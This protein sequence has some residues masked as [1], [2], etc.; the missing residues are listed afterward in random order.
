MIT[1]SSTTL[2]NL[3]DGSPLYSKTYTGLIGSAND[4]ANA[5]FYFAKIHPDS[6]T[7]NYKVKMKVQVTA[8]ESYAETIDIQFG[9]YGS[10]FSSFDAYTTR[11][12][13]VG[14]YYINLYRA[15]QVG[16]ST[17]HKGHALG[18]GL[19][20]SNNPTNTSYKRTVIIDILELDGCTIEMLDTAVKYAS[21]DGTG[22]TNYYGLTEMAVGT[23]GQNA[24]NNTNTHYTQYS[25]NVK[26]GTN[27]IKGYTLI[28]KDSENTWSCFY[29]GAYKVANTGKPVYTGGF[30]LGKIL[31]SAGAGAQTSDSSLD[32]YYNYKSG[33][34]TSTIYDAYPVDLR[35]STNCASTLT[36]QRPV[37]IVGTIENDGL[38][39]LDVSQWWTQTEPTYVDGKVYIYVGIAYSTYQV[40]LSTE[41]PAYVY[42]DGE[43][44]LYDKAQTLQ[45]INT[46][47]NSLETQI[48]SKV[49]TWC[50]KTNPASSWTAEERPN[51]TGD[52]WYYIGESTST[53]KNN[54]TYQYNG[55]TNVWSAYSANPDLFDKIDGKTAIYYGTTNSVISAEEGDYLVDSENDCTYRW[56][57]GAW[58]LAT[59]YKQVAIDAIEIGGRNLV[60]NTADWKNCPYAGDTSTVNGEEFIAPTT[61][62]TNWR[63]IN[64][65]FT[66]T[67]EDIYSSSIV[68]S[69]DVKKSDETP[70]SELVFQLFTT[71]KAYKTQTSGNL[72][73]GTRYYTNLSVNIWRNTENVNKDTWTRVYSIPIIMDEYFNT[74]SYTEYDY[75]A[76]YIGVKAATGSASF[77]HMKIELGNKATDWTPAPEDIE[78]SM[79]EK[80]DNIEIGGRNIL[81]NSA[82]NFPQKYGSSTLTTQSNVAIPE[83]NCTDGL[84]CYGKTG[85]GNSLCLLIN[86]ASHGLS[87][88]SATSVRDQ[89][90]VLSMYIKNNH[91]TNPFF[92]NSNIPSVSGTQ[93]IQ[94]GEAKRV[95]FYA[96]GNNYHVIQIVLKTNAAED[97]YDITFWHPQIEFGNKVTDWTPAPEDIEESIKAYAQSIQSQ[98]DGMAEIHYGTA[99]PTLN[100]APASAWTDTATKDMHVDDLY[101]NTSTGYCYRFT[102]SGSTYS[103]SRIKDSDIT[104]A[105]TAAGNAQ[106]TANNANTLA[107]QKRRI[108][109]SQPTPPYEVGDLWVE[110]SNGDIKKCKTARASG[111]YTANDWELASKYTDD[112]LASEAN[113]KI[114]NLEVGGRNLFGIGSDCATSLTGLITQNFSIVTEDGY[115]CAHA[116]GALGTTAHLTSKIPFTPKPLEK[117]VFSADIKIKDIVLGTTNPMCEFYFSGQ[118]INGSWRSQKVSNTY[119]DGE[120]VATGNSKF[121]LILPSNE[122][123]RVTVKWQFTDAE[124]TANMPPA[125]YLRDCTGEIF[126]KN[127]KYERGTQE[128]D[129]TP[130]PE[131]TQADIDTA[132]AQSV[133]YII[134]T[135]TAATN[136]WTGVTKDTSLQI[137]KTIVYYLP[138][139]G[140]TSAATLNLTLAGGGT[141]GAKNVR[142]NNTN[143]TNHYP[144]YS[145]ITLTYDGTYWRTSAY[146]SD[147]TNKTRL[148]NIIIAAEN[149]TAGHIICGTSSGYQNIA[150]YIDFDL[151]MPILYAGSSIAKGATS[152]TRDNNYLANSGVNASTNGTIE[153]GTI[154]KI[155]YL[156]GTITG[157][158]FHIAATPFMTTNTPNQEDDFYY[159]PLGIMYTTTNIYF[160][161]SNR[162]YAYIDGAFQPVDTAAVLRAQD[163]KDRATAV[164]GTCSTGATTVDK[165]VTC[166][167]FTLFDGARIQI[168]FTNANTAVASETTTNSPTLNINGT[169]A[170]PIKIGIETANATN[171][172]YWAAGAKIEFVYDGSAWILQNAPYTLYGSCN[173]EENV[174]EK[175]V[176]CD[177]AVVCKG[178]TIYVDMLYSNTAD[179]NSENGNVTLNVA[180]TIAKTIYANNSTLTT[181]SRYNWNAGEKPSFTFDGQYWQMDKDT[182]PAYI[183]DK[184][185]DGIFVHPVD[186]TTSGWSIGKVFELLNN[187]YSYIKMW[188]EDVTDNL[189]AKIRIG[190]EDQHHILLD[191]EIIQFKKGD[192][193]EELASFSSSGISFDD[194][195]PFKIGNDS[196]YVQFVDNNSDGVADALEIVADRI[197]FRN[198]GD[199]TTQD[200]QEK[201]DNL[202]TDVSNI[203]NSI[204]INPT[205]NTPYVAITTQDAQNT[206]INAG[207][208]LEPTQLSFQLNGQTTATMANDEMNIPTASVTNLFMQSANQSYEKIW[209]M[210]SNGHLSLKVGKQN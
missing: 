102:K 173:T 64:G 9:G 148:Q 187:G 129:W 174:R 167:N 137:G 23:A 112:T 185:E 58:V 202:Q 189:S 51:H 162:L 72:P 147:S 62:G 204:E 142:W 52:L 143:V 13:S 44:I 196:A 141:T 176:V 183:T 33:V 163:A 82:T 161:S 128:T 22:S 29:S 136:L 178:T 98:V 5:S 76:F 158:T 25:N 117:M 92:V 197:S 35:Y 155:L 111:S 172:L 107:G 34:N 97:D 87:V 206:N 205:A 21:I 40:W 67:K 184:D 55:E 53:Y 145:I 123:H 200:I 75:L 99:V 57:N 169:G 94:P 17:N 100:N 66:K 28:M 101:Y 24:T 146:N 12:G 56:N 150:P 121:H 79:Q 4:A 119:V 65:W 130:A 106:T 10:S 195:V 109:V 36:S 203:T 134:G 77:R 120:L 48:D 180:N 32:T 84:R 11:T 192:T 208:K 194:S 144:Q 131:D 140:T 122:W 156:K 80:V 83:F 188:L 90:Y 20:S 191:K 105:A 31:Y 159:I 37:Y 193:S 170:K 63:R 182:V 125:I 74:T 15:T 157:N 201:F 110:G 30:I 138:Y 127:I 47:K 39:H 114:D 153:L 88:S 2:A 91:E 186:D 43:F 3:K 93:S 71:N 166:S 124:F 199:N 115:K 198:G 95:V 104:A 133:E 42:Y 168:T 160:Q 19:R 26:A 126:V 175:Q 38:F 54:T 7:A 8:P 27:G 86:S 59:D 108:F 139:G 46:L 61:T 149:I 165:V 113:D 41:N 116:T 177:G 70:L 45:N 81:L 179:S 103:W 60:R 190:R 68:I 78:A 96:T 207:L 118:T 49:E 73:E 18:I 89:Q 14:V 210:R 85:T 135:Q 69:F 6:Y 164:Y 209:V 171:P 151:S 181:R 132:L 50:Q 152:G 154:G 1:Y 16:I